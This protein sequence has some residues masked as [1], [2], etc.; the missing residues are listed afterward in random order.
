[1]P[2]LKR[3]GVVVG[4]FREPPDTS[5]DVGTL[6]D[7]EQRRPYCIGPSKKRRRTV[8][9]IEQAPTPAGRAAAE[10]LEK[11]A[12][13]NERETEIRKGSDLEKGKDRIEE[14]S[15]SSDGRSAGEKQDL[16]TR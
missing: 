3:S 12:R 2:I 13:E 7:P 8:M 4:H 1:M 15:R 11:A 5:L 9:S 14:R 16:P 10:G 6:H